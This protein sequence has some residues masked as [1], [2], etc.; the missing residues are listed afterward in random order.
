MGDMDAKPDAERTELIADRPV[1]YRYHRLADGAQVAVAE[2]IRRND[3][4][5]GWQLRYGEWT[6]FP[7]AGTPDRSATA[8]LADAD[9]EM[10][11]RLNTLG[12]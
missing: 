10:R 8:A 11:F 5:D 3:S 1:R 2:H 9:R 6:D 4:D 7:D 12:K